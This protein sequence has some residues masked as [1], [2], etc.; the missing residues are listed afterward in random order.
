MRKLLF[1]DL[2]FLEALLFGS[3]EDLKILS[4]KIRERGGWGWVGLCC[5]LSCFAFSRYGFPLNFS[6]TWVSFLD[7]DEV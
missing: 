6:Q 3:P 2:D 5:L 4:V 7:N 1:P